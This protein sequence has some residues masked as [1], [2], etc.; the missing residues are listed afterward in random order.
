MVEDCRSIE[1]LTLPH[2]PKSLTIGPYLSNITIKLDEKFLEFLRISKRILFVQEEYMEELVNRSIRKLRR[3]EIENDNNF[4][5]NLGK[6]LLTLSNEI[7]LTNEK[8]S[9]KM[10]R[11]YEKSQPLE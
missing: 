9:P 5:L 4:M 1:A 11:C 2:L 7:S 3:R 10:K 6:E 8:T